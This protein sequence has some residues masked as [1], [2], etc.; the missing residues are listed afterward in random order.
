MTL[1][2]KLRSNPDVAKLDA[3]ILESK[4]AD[5]LIASMQFKGLINLAFMAK[6]RS[7]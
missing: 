3:V 7:E 4:E 5:T 1:K 6:F 2:N